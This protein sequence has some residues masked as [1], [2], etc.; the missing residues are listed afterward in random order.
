LYQKRKKLAELE[1]PPE[2][3]P[4]GTFTWWAIPMDK[5]MQVARDIPSGTLLFVVRHDYQNI[6]YRISHVAIVLQKKTG[7]YLR[8]AKD[9]GAHAVIDMPL[10]ALIKRNGEYTRWPVTGY[11][12]YLPQQPGK[13]TTAA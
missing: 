6:P 12:L 8:H 7:T 9:Q 1:L 5:M 11:S 10:E 13:S 2:K 3:I 4:N